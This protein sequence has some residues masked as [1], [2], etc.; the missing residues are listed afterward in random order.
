MHSPDRANQP[1]FIRRF[2]SETQVIAHLEHRHIVPLYNYWRDPEGAFL[3]MRWLRGG[4]LAQQIK[5]QGE[6]SL[7]DTVLIVDQLAQAP[8][9]AHHSGIIH[10]DIK[11]GNILL[12]EDNN[13]F[14]ADSGIAKDYARSQQV[15]EPDGFLGSPEYLAPEQARREPV[16]PQTDVTSLGVVLYERLEGA[17]PFPNLSHIE[18]LY[19]HLNDPLPAL[20][21]VDDGIRDDLND[22][23]SKPPPKTPYPVSRA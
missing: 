4:S 5:S 23:S 8:H 12:D 19:R 22:V 14:F 17:H 13:A 6:L 21:T 9:H 1:D 11:P 18:L 3:V 15:S 2:E 16:T 10:R 20:Q 7:E